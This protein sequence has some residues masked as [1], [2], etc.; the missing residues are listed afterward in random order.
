MKIDVGAPPAIGRDSY[1]QGDLQ[2][3][4]RVVLPGLAFVHW[5]KQLMSMEYL[6]NDKQAIGVI[7]LDKR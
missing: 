6:D 7:F 3:L 5:L 2:A 1:P 4:G